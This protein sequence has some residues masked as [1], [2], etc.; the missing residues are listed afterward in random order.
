MNILNNQ[1]R[2]PGKVE[3]QVLN[4]AK[5]ANQSGLDGIVCSAAEIR[6]VK[7]KLPKDF[8]YV[9]PGIKA[10]GTRAINDQKRVLSPGDAVQNGSSILVVGRAITA[11]KTAEERLRAGY[12]VLKDMAKYL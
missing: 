3:E 11:H 12:E 9:T 8:M 5:L 7:D 2:V 6:A 4:Y 1:L 10:P